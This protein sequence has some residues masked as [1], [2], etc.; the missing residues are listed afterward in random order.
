MRQWWNASDWVIR[1]TGRKTC[2]SVTLSTPHPTCTFFR[3]LLCLSSFISHLPQDLFMKTSY[4]EWGH[5]EA[6]S[7]PT[8][9]Q[10]P[11]LLW[12]SGCSLQFSQ[13]P[14]PDV[15]S[16]P[17]TSMPHSQKQFETCFNIMLLNSY[18]RIRL[19]LSIQVSRVKCCYVFIDIFIHDLI[20]SPVTGLEWPRGFQE[21]KVPRFHDNGTGWW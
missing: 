4:M 17:H 10:V 21:F 11:Q 12:N 1:S 3:F 20:S 16:K 14:D 9:Q 5:L 19:V 18:R 6:D 15:Y 8:T 2:P 13:K 7:R